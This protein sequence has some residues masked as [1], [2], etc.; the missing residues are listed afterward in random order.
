MPTCD[1]VLLTPICQ[2]IARLQPK[3]VLDIGVG[4]G[5]WGFL[6]REYT[7]IWNER[8]D[9]KTWKTVI[10]GVDIFPNYKNPIWKHYYNRVYIDD[11][12]NIIDLLTSYD[13]IIFTEVLEHIEKD[14]ALILLNKVMQKGK[15]VIFSYTNSVQGSYNGNENECHISNWSYNDVKK[16]NPRLLT[17]LK[18]NDIVIS[19]IFIKE[20][21]H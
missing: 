21:W 4:S 10:D 11:I 13:L 9:K 14:K 17:R 7:D 5:K 6:T 2:E 16:Y 20:N 18:Y 15:N 3:T 1:P 12:N 8:Y 19:E